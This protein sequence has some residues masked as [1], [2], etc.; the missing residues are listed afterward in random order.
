MAC[1]G[2]RLQAF[3]GCRDRGLGA[4]F[5]DQHGQSGEACRKADQASQR[6]L[7]GFASG[8]GAPKR[9]GPNTGSVRCLRTRAG[10]IPIQTRW[11]LSAG[12][13]DDLRATGR[14]RVTD[15]LVGI[16]RGPDGHVAFVAGRELAEAGLRAPPRRGRG[17]G[18]ETGAT[19]RMPA[20]PT[21]GGLSGHPQGNDRRLGRS[22]PQ[23]IPEGAGSVKRV[24]G[25]FFLL[26]PCCWARRSEGSGSRLGRSPTAER[27]EGLDG[28]PV[29]RIL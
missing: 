23:V 29:Q 14:C 9:F 7:A 12:V 27:P 3:G 18:S 19:S 1:G 28:D 6:R 17:A 8:G 21:R 20:R 15:S 2:N 26:R 25:V 10:S 5:A 4:Q 24:G 22:F 16:Q 13:A 11:C